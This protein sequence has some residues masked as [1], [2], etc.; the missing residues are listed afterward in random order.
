MTRGQNNVTYMMG[1]S[2]ASVYTTGMA[3]GVAWI[4]SLV[5]TRRPMKLSA[6]GWQGRFAGMQNDN[7]CSSAAQQ[8][9]NMGMGEC[10]VL[11]TLTA[12]C[13]TCGSCFDRSRRSVRFSMTWICEGLRCGSQRSSSSAHTSRSDA[14]AMISSGHS[15][16]T[17]SIVGIRIDASCQLAACFAV[18]HRGAGHEHEPPGQACLSG[19]SIIW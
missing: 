19:L 12:R 5:R 2:M 10:R 1:L 7:E 18:E 6:T 17:S 16:C 15:S 8:V 4:R 9:Q 3:E 11:E 13:S 14:G